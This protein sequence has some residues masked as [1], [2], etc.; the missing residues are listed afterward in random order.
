M[1]NPLVPYG[2]RASKGTIFSLHATK[3][4]RGHRRIAPVILNLSTSYRYVTT[5]TP[6]PFYPWEKTMV[7]IQLEASLDILE[8]KNISCTYQG[9]NPNHPACSLVITSSPVSRLR[10]EYRFQEKISEQQNC[11]CSH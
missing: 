5:F 10:G 7:A 4:S 9:S 2:E 6:K 1:W 8:K 3:A 11:S